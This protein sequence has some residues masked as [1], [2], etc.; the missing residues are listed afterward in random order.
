MIANT[1][2]DYSNNRTTLFE[3]LDGLGEPNFCWAFLNGE[4]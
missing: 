3:P 4:S 1:R 2:L